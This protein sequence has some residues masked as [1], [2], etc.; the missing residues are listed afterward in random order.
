MYIK[1]SQSLFAGNIEGE[2]TVFLFKK[3]VS[4]SDWTTTRSLN[5]VLI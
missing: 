4:Y 2:L 5:K 3:A 1:N